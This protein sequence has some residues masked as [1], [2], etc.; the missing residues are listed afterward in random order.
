MLWNSIL[1]VGVG[2]RS[3]R[4]PGENPVDCFRVRVRVGVRTGLG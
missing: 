3:H 1:L 4:G 2:L